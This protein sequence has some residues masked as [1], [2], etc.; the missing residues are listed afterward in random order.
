MMTLPFGM[1]LGDED[2]TERGIPR[3]R[4]RHTDKTDKTKKAANLRRHGRGSK[5]TD[6]EEERGMEESEEAVESHI[7]RLEN[8][9]VSQNK[10]NQKY[11]NGSIERVQR[12]RGFARRI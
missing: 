1:E 7:G 10:I 12:R 9:Q 4:R 5:R 2:N 3:L 6:R 8:K 11:L